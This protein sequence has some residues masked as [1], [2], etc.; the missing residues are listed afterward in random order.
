M[1]RPSD[2]NL[3]PKTSSRETLVH[4]TRVGS[5]SRR[6]WCSTEVR[7][8]RS[9]QDAVRTA[10]GVLLLWRSCRDVGRDPSHRREP[11]EQ[12]SCKPQSRA[13][14]MSPQSSQPQTPENSRTAGKDESRAHWG[15]AH[16]RASRQHQCCV[17]EILGRASFQALSMPERLRANAC[18]YVGGA[19]CK[20][21]PE[22]EHT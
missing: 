14:R 2:D 6:E 8:D 11:C 19:A 16:G 22:G 20:G 1:W 17:E 5:S 21:V 3:V 13:R 9:S 4:G 12:P 7:T 10:A 15:R 18:R